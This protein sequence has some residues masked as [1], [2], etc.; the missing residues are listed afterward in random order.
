VI[1]PT[2]EGANLTG[3]LALQTERLGCDPVKISSSPSLGRGR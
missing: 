1:F 2:I 3:E